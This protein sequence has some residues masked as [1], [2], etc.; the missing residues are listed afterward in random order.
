MEINIHTLSEGLGIDSKSFRKFLRSGNL[1]DKAKKVDGNWT[2]DF[3]NLADPIEYIKNLM[4]LSAKAPRTPKDPSAFKNKKEKLQEV[5]SAP[6]F[7]NDGLPHWFGVKVDG[8]REME[9]KEAI[10]HFNIE[11][12]MEVFVP[13]QKLIKNGSERIQNILTKIVFVRTNSIMDIIKPIKDVNSKIKGFWMSM[14]IDKAGNKVPAL[15]DEETV[16][17]L[18]ELH[19]RTI[20][21]EQVHGFEVNKLVEIIEGPFKHQKGFILRVNG[22]IIN[23]ELEILG[24][25]LPLHISSSQLKLIAE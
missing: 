16:L 10:E 14:P 17:S 2:F 19:N 1:E 3:S 15:I 24:R 12:V 9:V 11:K 7:I 23:I 22:D 6:D 20:T 5:F 25:T 8:G 4:R 13:T 21:D 18:K